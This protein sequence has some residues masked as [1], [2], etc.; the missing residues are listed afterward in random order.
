[1]HDKKE[2]M[3]GVATAGRYCLQVENWLKGLIRPG[4]ML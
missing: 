1:M 2:T 3:D 4:E